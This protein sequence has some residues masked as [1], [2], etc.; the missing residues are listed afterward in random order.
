MTYIVSHALITPN[1]TPFPVGFSTILQDNSLELNGK[2]DYSNGK[3]L[4]DLVENLVYESLE[5][6]LFF[7]CVLLW[8]IF[9]LHMHMLV[10]CSHAHCTDRLWQKKLVIKDQV[11]LF[12]SQLPMHCSVYLA[13]QTSMELNSAYEAKLNR[14]WTITYHIISFNFQGR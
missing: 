11:R 6:K 7:G 3:V 1:I 13:C 8:G 14:S 12:S 5:T 10:L 2:F 9:V 4:T